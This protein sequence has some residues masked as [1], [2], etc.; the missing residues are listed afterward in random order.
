MLKIMLIVMLCCSVVTMSFAE[1]GM[2]ATENQVILQAQWQ[3]SVPQTEIVLKEIVG[4]LNH[5][6]EH[7][8]YEYQ[9]VATQKIL[10]Q[11]DQYRVQFRGGIKD[12]KQI[13]DCN[14]FPISDEGVEWS[15]VPVVVLD[16]GYDYWRI[17]FDV[18]TGSCLNFY[19]NGDA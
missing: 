19:V 18:D 11:M 14:F 13:V 9:I 16:G 3:P 12:G 10:A 2:V 17:E 8:D 5:I 4:Y 1:G 7:T 15:R 6:E